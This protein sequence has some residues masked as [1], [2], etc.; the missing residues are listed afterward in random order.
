MTVI[1][2]SYNYI[3][4]IIGYNYFYKTDKKDYYE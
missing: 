3:T 1:P 2:V 4:P